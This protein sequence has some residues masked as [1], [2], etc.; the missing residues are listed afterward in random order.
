MIQNDINSLLG[1]LLRENIVLEIS[2]FRAII[3]DIKQALS[4]NNHL[5]VVFRYIS[6][7]K[8]Y[9]NITE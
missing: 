9:Y 7:T 1:T 6:I 5:F 8:N 2:P 3:M 4:K